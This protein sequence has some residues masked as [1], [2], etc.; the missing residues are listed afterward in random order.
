MKICVLGSGANG[1]PVRGEPDHRSH[2]ARRARPP[3]TRCQTIGVF[4]A[5]TWICD[6][7]LWTVDLVVTGL[8]KES[9]SL[10]D[11]RG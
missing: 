10:N 4:V 5:T 6:C 7:P 9:V 1:L 8:P 2:V 11:Y 3:D